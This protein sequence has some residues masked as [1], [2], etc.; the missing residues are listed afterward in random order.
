VAV[1]VAI[2]ARLALSATPDRH[3]T[4]ARCAARLPLPVARNAI[5]VLLL[6]PTPGATMYPWD[7]DLLPTAD[8]RTMAPRQVDHHQSA[9]LPTAQSPAFR[10][11]LP[12][13]AVAAGL[14]GAP[15]PAGRS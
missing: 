4:L 5:P 15:H 12:S 3:V 6:N 14:R 11:P 10:A 2:P 7:L 13:G 8:L 9:N 1:A